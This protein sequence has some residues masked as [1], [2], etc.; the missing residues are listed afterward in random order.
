MIDKYE[1][2]QEKLKQVTH[3]SG[4]K[5]MG[6]LLEIVN[7]A[8][9]EVMLKTFKNAEIEKCLNKEPAKLVAENM[10][11]KEV[12]LQQTFDEDANFIKER[13]SNIQELLLDIQ[14]QDENLN[15]I[16]F[17]DF[18]EVWY[19]DV[20]EGK[21]SINSGNMKINKIMKE[22]QLVFEKA[23]ILLRND[24]KSQVL[25]VD[26][27]SSHVFNLKL[28]CNVKAFIPVIKQLLENYPAETKVS[29][30]E[31]NMIL[32]KMLEVQLLLEKVPGMSEK[33]KFLNDVCSKHCAGNEALLE[34]ETPFEQILCVNH[35]NFKLL[36]EP[37][38]KFDASKYCV[39]HV[40]IKGSKTHLSLL[41][42]KLFIDEKDQAYKRNEL[43]MTGVFK[44]PQNQ[45]GPQRRQRRK[46]MEVLDKAVL[47][48]SSIVDQSFLEKS[49]IV[50]NAPCSTP[51]SSTM[52][53][54][55]MHQNIFGLNLSTVSE[56]SVLPTITKKYEKK[57]P[58]L[59]DHHINNIPKVM[60]T[61][62]SIIERTICN[63]ENFGT[64]ILI[65]DNLMDISDSCLTE[66]D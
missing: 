18:I 29:E 36:R 64:E 49:T 43:N 39:T 61:D 3:P 27:G 6:L 55:Q 25:T 5:F 14:N 52:L 47:S 42:D 60:F 32:K 45:A 33:C 40:E 8:A 23:K 41:T 28:I 22:S 1:L 35:F 2:P 20:M 44:I 59:M 46:A 4:K 65:D 34:A 12:E 37:P 9:K 31:N 17:K 51:F 57:I 53:L 50:H 19:S 63:K 15:G 66:V 10:H 58:V 7:I 54:P 48:K 21:K 26:K 13:I 30:S 16:E 11:E 62:A 38:L 24:F 56:I